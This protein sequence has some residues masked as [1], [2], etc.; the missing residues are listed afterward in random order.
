MDETITINKADLDWVVEE[1]NRSGGEVWFFG[2]EKGCRILERLGLLLGYP[3]L[4]E[5]FDFEFDLSEGE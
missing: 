4:A 1:A 3:T 2:S 5:R